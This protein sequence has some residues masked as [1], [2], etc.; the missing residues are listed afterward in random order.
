MVLLLGTCL[1]FEASAQ[2]LMKVP[3]GSESFVFFFFPK[4]SMI[5]F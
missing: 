1:D 2:G 3:A 5:R 4:Q